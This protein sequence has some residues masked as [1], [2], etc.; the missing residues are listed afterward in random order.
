MAT[1]KATAA[2][3]RQQER[4]AAAQKRA[5]T[6]ARLQ[7]RAAVAA[8]QKADRGVSHPHRMGTSLADYCRCQHTHLVLR[9]HCPTSRAITP[10]KKRS[11]PPKVQWPR[12]QHRSEPLWVP[13]YCLKDMS[14]LQ[15]QRIL[16]VNIKVR[17]ASICV[18]I[19]YVA[20][21]GHLREL[22]MLCRCAA[23][24]QSG[25]GACRAAAE[26]WVGA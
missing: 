16:I 17:R 19:G 5:T 26:R 12:P 2:Q 6:K 15:L 13:R 18:K 23:R 4:T 24:C 3:Q 25:A 21:R 1:G 7:K 22:Y 14:I 10:S 9:K 11:C 20:E 8:E